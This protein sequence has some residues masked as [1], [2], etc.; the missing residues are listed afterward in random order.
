[1]LCLEANNIGNEGCFHL[2]KED[3]P[4]LEDLNLRKLS[5]I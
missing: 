1:M 4:N 2:S 5:E 3:N